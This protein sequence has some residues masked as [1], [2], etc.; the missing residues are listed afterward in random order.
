MGAVTEVCCSSEPKKQETINPKPEANKEKL[1]DK[2][3][4]QSS[5]PPTTNVVTTPKSKREVPP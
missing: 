3:Q 1:K 5:T 2:S 4:N